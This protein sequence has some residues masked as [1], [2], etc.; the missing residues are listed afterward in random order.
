[1]DKQVRGALLGVGVAFIAIFG[2]MTLV[3]LAT[4]ELNFASI[5]AFGLSFLVI[6]VTL[7]GLIGAIRNPPGEDD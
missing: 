1:M 5:M 4:A 3:A 2:G 7:F 6:V